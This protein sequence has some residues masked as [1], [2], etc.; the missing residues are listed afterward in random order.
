MTFVALVF[1][2]LAIYWWQQA[3]PQL[4]EQVVE[5]WERWVDYCWQGLAQK[6]WGRGV[7]GWSLTILGTAVV[8][9]ALVK[10]ISGNH[11]LALLLLHVL[12]LTVALGPIGF[13]EDMDTAQVLRLVSCVFFYGVFGILGLVSVRLL[14]TRQSQAVWTQVSEVVIPWVLWVPARVV[15]ISYALVGNFHTCMHFLMA[16]GLALPRDGEAEE[17]VERGSIAAL[18][19][20]WDEL[21]AP[22]QQIQRSALNR[23]ALLAL[24]VILALVSIF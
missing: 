7:A 24:L 17:L 14:L 11:L 6:S 20:L 5:L 22:E 12:V 8:V 9:A 18:E 10:I 15:V 23:R 3:Y 4:A 19:P 1:A 13:D 2:T 16:K 21:T